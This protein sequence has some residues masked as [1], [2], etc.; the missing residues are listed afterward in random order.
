M[1]YVY[2]VM[3]AL[4]LGLFGYKKFTT[5]KKTNEYLPKDKKK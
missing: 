2:L 5:S 1:E 3:A 4:V